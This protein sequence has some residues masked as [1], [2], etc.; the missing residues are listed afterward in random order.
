MTREEAFPLLAAPPGSQEGRSSCP[1]SSPWQQE[2]AAVSSPTWDPDGIPTVLRKSG[3]TKAA[4]HSHH[5]PKPFSRAAGK[6]HG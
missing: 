6:T 2:Q 4:H 1:G 3:L 5:S